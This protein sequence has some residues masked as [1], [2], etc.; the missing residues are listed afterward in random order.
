MLATLAA[1][2]VTRYVIAG[3]GRLLRA[4]LRANLGDVEVHLIERERDLARVTP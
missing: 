3:P 2:G 1:R 4:L